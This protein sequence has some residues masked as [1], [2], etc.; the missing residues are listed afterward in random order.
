MYR[1]INIHN[2]SWHRGCVISS[3]SDSLLR[4]RRGAL[5]RAILSH[6]A[7]SHGQRKEGAEDGSV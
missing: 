1:Y 3:G 4:G 5:S 2:R 7:L 6:T